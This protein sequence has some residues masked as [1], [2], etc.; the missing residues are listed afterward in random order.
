MNLKNPAVLSALTLT[1]VV[2]ILM[3]GGSKT[4]AA[5]GGPVCNVPAD[6][7][8][9]QAAVNAPGCTTI[10]VA[11]GTYTEN[12]SI[13]RTLTLN[14]AQHGHDAR[15]RSGAESTINGAGGPNVTITANNVTVDGFT[16]LGP[17]NQGTAA[18]VM[19][20][21]NS[22]E[23][24]QNNIIQNPGRAASYNTSSTTFF[25]NAVHATATAGDGFQ[26]NSSPVSN[27]SILNNSFDGATS[28][29]YNTD[30]NIL[31]PGST[32]IMVAGNSSQTDSTLV[33]LFQTNG[34]QITCNTITNPTGSAIYIGGGDSNITVTGNRITGGAFSAVRVANA[35]GDGPNSN[36][37]VTGNTLKNN[38][39]GVNVGVL[40]ITAGDT[41]QVHQ[42]N[43]TGNSVFGVN[44]DSTGAVDATNN[45]WGAAN[46]PGPVG[47]GSGDKVSIGVTFKPWLRSANRNSPCNGDNTCSQQGD[48][49]DD[50]DKKDKDEKRD[51]DDKRDN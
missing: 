47:P 44:N 24:I 16:L 31:G 50:K 4:R 29:N 45:W 28:P 46:G 41:V 10:N 5:V 26:E 13:A 2:G 8:T 18:V 32:G 21:G 49:K 34:A 33:A 23:R 39:Y 30:I 25:Q 42:N 17:V 15:G 48:D 3:F 40:S 20:G 19:N 1:L 7:P 35:F 27:I 9:I 37:T 51:K 6:Y 36:I 43:I 22:G 38:G 11:P 12:V 14:G